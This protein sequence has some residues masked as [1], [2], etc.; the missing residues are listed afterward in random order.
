MK[1][2]VG[3]QFERAFCHIIGST[4]ANKINSGAVFMLL[5]Y[6]VFSSFIAETWKRIVASF[7]FSIYL[8]AQ[9]ITLELHRFSCRSLAV[10]LLAVQ[11]KAMPAY[12]I[13]YC[14]GIP[15]KFPLSSCFRILFRY[16]AEWPLRVNLLLY[17]ILSYFYT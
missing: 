17:F 7:A 2:N 4:R 3:S 15:S 13:L 9:H 12:P 8:L 14:S 10:R 5:D 6:A 16:F 1:L 11:I